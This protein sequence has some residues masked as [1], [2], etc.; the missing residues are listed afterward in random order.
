VRQARAVVIPLVIDENL[1]LVLEAAERA[2]VDDP[3]A[4]ALIEGT[5]AVVCFRVAPAAR[6]S[7][8]LRVLCERA[9]DA[10]E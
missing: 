6:E 9:L 3:V 1:R 8:R 7:A 10:L 2:R 5:V 4:I